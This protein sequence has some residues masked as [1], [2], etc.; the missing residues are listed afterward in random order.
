MMYQ[1]EY[2]TIGGTYPNDRHCAI[3]V[4]DEGV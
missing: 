4:L 3:M 2:S 1:E